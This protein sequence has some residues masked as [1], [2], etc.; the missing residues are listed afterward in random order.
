M[1]LTAPDSRRL[2]DALGRFA[3]GVTVVSC[4]SPAGEWLGITAN[5]F[6]AVSL[7][8][9]LVLVSLDRRLQSLPGFLEAGHFG[10]NVLAACQREVSDRF[11]RRG[12]EKW[13]PMQVREGTAGTPLLAEALAVFDCARWAVYD[14]GDHVILVGRVLRLAHR[15]EDGPLVY[16]GGAYRELSGERAPA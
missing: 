4:R 9:P 2:R 1:Q 3:T 7:D 14:G 8:P 13:Q 5:S 16:F 15:A 11:A 10:V 6:N 12:A